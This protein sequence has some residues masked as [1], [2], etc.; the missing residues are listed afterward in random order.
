VVS[1][2]PVPRPPPAAAP[3]LP[4]VDPFGPEATVAAPSHRASAA[5]TLPFW[6]G[7]GLGSGVGWHQRRD[8]EAQSEF[9]VPAGIATAALIHLSPEIGYRYGPRTAFSVQS[10]HQLIPVTGTV[11]GADRQ[12]MAHALFLRAHRLLLSDNQLEVWG[13]AAVGGGS[14]IRLY[15]PQHPAAGLEASDTVAVGP[16][17]FGPGVSVV[18]RTSSRL[19]IVGEL[20]AL[21]AAWRWAALADLAIG[22]LYAF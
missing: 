10:R 13:T 3:D 1:A 5:G 2:P 21:V 20:R 16:L 4:A 7:L 18:Y 14:A 9:F 11:G 17:A 12:R 6:V 8:L 15:I 19:A 22:A